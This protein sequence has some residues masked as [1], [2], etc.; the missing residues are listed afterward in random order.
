V[1]FALGLR[2]HGC[3]GST[4]STRVGSRKRQVGIDAAIAALVKDSQVTWLLGS[5]ILI[6]LDRRHDQ[7]F[8]AGTMIRRCKDDIAARCA[9]Q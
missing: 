6:D 4:G 7:V 8:F 9:D 3:R 2:C 1:A 5:S